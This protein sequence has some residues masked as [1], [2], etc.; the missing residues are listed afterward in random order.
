LADIT[1]DNGTLTD[2]VVDSVALSDSSHV[3]TVEL[4]T[5]VEGGVKTGLAKA[6]DTAHVTGDMGIQLLAVRSDTA[7]AIA[8]NGDYI[9]LIVDATGRL[10]VNVSGVAA[11]DIGKAEDAAHTSGATGV[12][13]LGVRKDTA[14]ATSAADGD[15]NPLAVDANGRLHVNV[16]AA[17]AASR[18]VDSVAA[19]LSVDRLMNNLTAVTP[20]MVAIDAATGGDN[21]LVGAQG[22][23]NIILVHHVCL[24]ASAAVTVRFES[25]AGGTALTGQMVLAA[26]GGFVLPFNPVGWFK[27]AGNALLNLELSGAV[28]VDGVLG[29]TV[30][31]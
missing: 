6:E 12:M 24:V 27:T 19:T 8:A 5:A 21:T 14:A 31:T 20:T 17:L 16:G 22:S 30:V 25:G 15:Y 4:V 2:F 9:P 23:G 18:T 7:A 29:Y 1:V 11:T 3:Q 13:A 28:S 10:H 26:N